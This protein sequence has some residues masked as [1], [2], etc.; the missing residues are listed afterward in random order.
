M[1]SSFGNQMQVGREKMTLMKKQMAA[2]VKSNMNLCNISYAWALSSGIIGIVIIVIIAYKY[3]VNKGII[4][5]G[6]FGIDVSVGVGNAEKRKE[7]FV[8]SLKETTKLRKELNE[9]HNRTEEKVKQKLKDDGKTDVEIEK[10]LKE[11]KTPEKTV[12]IPDSEMLS[13]LLQHLYE[14]KYAL[15]MGICCI[16]LA[17]VIFFGAG[18][19]LCGAGDVEV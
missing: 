9:M 5:G 7:S 2:S 12:E 16:C 18:R 4:R 19:V 15:G 11:V 3:A 14:K 13:R 10:L 6:L 1:S 8:L 17:T